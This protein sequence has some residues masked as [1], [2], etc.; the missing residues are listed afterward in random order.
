M[1]QR[2]FS[3]ACAFAIA[4]CFAHPSRAEPPIKVTVDWSKTIAV[5]KTIPTIIACP[6]QPGPAAAPR[7]MLH[8]A[9]FTVLRKLNT[10]Y[11]RW[12]L[13]DP[14]RQVAEIYPPTPEK[15]SWDS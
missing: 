6:F 1:N 8:E 13:I 12:H 3:I 10:Q 9:E 15:T 2:H 14:A 11:V 4:L 5:S 7:S